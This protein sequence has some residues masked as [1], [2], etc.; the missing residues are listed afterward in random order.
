MA[1]HIIICRQKKTYLVFDLVRQ[2][3]SGK[4][5]RSFATLKVILFIHTRTNYLIITQNTK[6]IIPHI[7]VYVE[8]LLF[9]SFYQSV[10][11]LVCL[12]VKVLNDM[13]EIRFTEQLYQID[14]KKFVLNQQFYI[15][16]EP[17]IARIF[18]CN[19]IMF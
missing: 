10:S 4:I 7:I 9:N 2:T 17:K 6:K 15:R 3:F 11:L 12:Y 14:E 1:K 5:Q 19:Q 8:D 13:E 18:C 16:A